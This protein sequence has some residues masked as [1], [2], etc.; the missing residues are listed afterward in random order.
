MFVINVRLC[1][2][3]NESTSKS[4]PEVI[5]FDVVWGKVNVHVALIEVDELVVR[6]KDEL[7]QL[8]TDLNFWE[9][10]ESKG[11]GYQK[12]DFMEGCNQ[13][14]TFQRYMI[15]GKAFFTKNSA[16]QYLIVDAEKKQRMFFNNKI[17]SNLV[18]LFVTC[19]LHSIYIT[20]L[21]HWP[22]TCDTSLDAHWRQLQ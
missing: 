14:T 7:W 15:H 9:M 4:L 11:S 20:S 12:R 21:V 17:C 1:A 3:F 5:S 16:R 10:K 22:Y 2:A 8:W 18:T 13:E 6:R 19:L